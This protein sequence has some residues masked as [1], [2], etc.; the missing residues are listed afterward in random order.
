MR[1]LSR[2]IPG[3]LFAAVLMAVPAGVHAAAPVGVSTPARLDASARLDAPVPARVQAADHDPA[4][5]FDDPAASLGRA[6]AALTAGQR[7]FETAAASWSW[8]RGDAR[9]APNTGGVVALGLVHA[10]EEAA[11]R[12]RA[13]AIPGALDAARAWGEARLEDVAEWR[14]L[15]DPDV[16]ALSALARFTGDARFSAGAKAAFERRWSGA[17]G[18]EVVGRLRLLRAR[19]PE[20]VGYDAALTVRAALSVGEVAFATEIAD[21]LLAARD[22]WDRAP[23]LQG[24]D[25]HGLSTTGRASVLGALAAVDA[26]RADAGE[27]ARYAREIEALMV[28]LVAAQHAEGS[29]AQRNTQTTAYAV[30]ALAAL[31]SP[32]A[33][34]AAARGARWLGA[35]Q[36][37][38]GHWASFNDGLP[39]PFVGD[40]VH[41]VTAE[42]ALALAAV[43]R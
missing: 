18:D 26:A 5:S 34:E 31:D 23:A 10:F 15:Y 37:S 41:E 40:V 20:L 17:K 14:S 8:R 32:M 2:P 30:R 42:V 9:P 22:T 11:A 28:W 21:A 39:E 13:R 35:T 1:A 25:V 33:R 4:A 24:T 43:R 29:W 16:E 19:R 7:D 3:L 36:L 27:P 38:D 6:A 12:G